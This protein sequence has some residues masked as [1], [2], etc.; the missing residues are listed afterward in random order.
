MIL[1]NCQLDAQILLNVFIYLFIV[2]YMFRACHAR[3][4]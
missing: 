4:M 1:G 3:N 2:L